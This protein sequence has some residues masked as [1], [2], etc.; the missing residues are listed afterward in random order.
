M[1]LRLATDEEIKLATGNHQACSL[2]N[3]FQPEV[4]WASEARWRLGSRSFVSSLFAWLSNAFVEAHIETLSGVTHFRWLREFRSGSR[5]ACRLFSLDFIRESL[6]Q[7]EFINVA[8]CFSSFTQLRPREYSHLSHRKPWTCCRQ[9]E[10]LNISVGNLLTN[11]RHHNLTR[12]RDRACPE[13]FAS[14]R[15]VSGRAI[16]TKKTFAITSIEFRTFRWD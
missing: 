1:I 2:C 15:R 16:A 13:L 10:K 5:Y 4:R 11:L 8:C 14:K 6:W 9:R 7:R 3:Y 12:E